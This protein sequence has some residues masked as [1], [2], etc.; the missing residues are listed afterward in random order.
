MA[1]LASRRSGSKNLETF[2]LLWLDASVNATE[3]NIQA[4]QCLRTSINCLE[5][6]ENDEQCECYIQSLSSQDRVVFIVSGRLGKV[7]VPRLHSLRQLSSIYV[8]CMDKKTNEQWANKFAKVINIL[9]RLPQRMAK[10][11]IG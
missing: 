1:A 8:Y 5:T 4:Q 2:Y 10:L 11:D 9:I 3:E 7:I 6:F